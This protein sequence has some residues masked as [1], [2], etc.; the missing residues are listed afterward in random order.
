MLQPS[1]ATALP[2]AFHFIIHFIHPTQIPI[3]FFLPFIRFPSRSVSSPIIIT[4]THRIHFEGWRA[5]A[6]DGNCFSHAITRQHITS[7]RMRARCVPFQEIDTPA[8]MADAAHQRKSTTFRSFAA[9]AVIRPVVV[10]LISVLSCV[11]LITTLASSEYIWI[12]T[13]RVFRVTYF[14]RCFSPECKSE[15]KKIIFF[16]FLSAEGIVLSI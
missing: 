13:W 4:A 8:S 10:A 11:F 15:R 16:V 7:M 5:F 12:L 6:R 3:F 2:H 9:A 14:S 1:A